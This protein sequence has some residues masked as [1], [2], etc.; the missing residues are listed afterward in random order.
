MTI[1]VSRGG[2]GTDPEGGGFWLWRSLKV[3]RRL[4][5]ERPGKNKNRSTG[6]LLI[7]HF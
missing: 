3:T 1:R 2:V 4:E 7:L 6:A 5:K